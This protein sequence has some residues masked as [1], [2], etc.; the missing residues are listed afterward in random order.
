MRCFQARK[1]GG[2]A[3]ITEA[4]MADP[5]KNADRRLDRAS[6][7]AIRL[8]SELIPALE[9]MELAKEELV[10]AKG[11]SDGKL[12]G[13]RERLGEAARK[14]ERLVAELQRAT[15]EI[16]LALEERENGGRVVF[17]V[18]E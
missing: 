9:E 6:G 8:G 1:M 5:L 12:D 10:R 15:E 2:A 11:D 16:G 17:E 18:E 3:Q 7:E 4:G 14:V 13:F